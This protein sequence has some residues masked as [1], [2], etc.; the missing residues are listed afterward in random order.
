MKK[1]SLRRGFTLIEIL[2]VISII[3]ILSA[4]VY[5]NLGHARIEAKNKAMQASLK[6][7]GLALGVYKSL[8]NHYPNSTDAADYAA[9]KTLL[10][11]EGFLAKMPENAD[12]ANPNCVISY[13]TDA[14]GSYYKM[15]ELYCHEGITGV[16]DDGV[17]PRDRL[18]RC[19]DT[20]SDCGGDTYNATY[21]ATIP[22]YETYAIY[23]YGGQCK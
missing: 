14:G 19:P 12:S 20:C 16:A 2:V 10:V 23:S 13:K 6:E 1:Y 15:T 22:F 8:N 7:V 21:T 17:Q 4:I 9:L 5:G 11:N 3:G 18:A